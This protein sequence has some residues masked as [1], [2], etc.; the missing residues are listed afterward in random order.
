MKYLS[1]RLRLTGALPEACYV[2]SAEIL[3][4]DLDSDDGDVTQGHL[5]CVTQCDTQNVCPLKV[6]LA[7]LFKHGDC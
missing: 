6:F 2:S 4:R 5:H 7:Y 1:L 3:S